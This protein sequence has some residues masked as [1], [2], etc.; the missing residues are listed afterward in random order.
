MWFHPLSEPEGRGER[1]PLLQLRR[2]ATVIVGR[3]STWEWS[4]DTRM[5][6]WEEEGGERRACAMEASDYKP[7]RRGPRH[8]RVSPARGLDLACWCSSRDRNWAS[9]VCSAGVTRT[10]TSSGP[11]NPFSAAECLRDRVR[12][13]ARSSLSGP[14][15]GRELGRGRKVRIRMCVAKLH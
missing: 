5:C 10:T 3:V 13:P 1:Y 12:G 14:S 4:W 8:R 9:R 7:W 6:E 2:D 11:R 15:C